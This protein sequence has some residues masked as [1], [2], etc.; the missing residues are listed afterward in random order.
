LLGFSSPKIAERL[1]LPGP[2]LSTA[3]GPNRPEHRVLDELPEAVRTWPAGQDRIRVDTG[4]WTKR[5]NTRRELVLQKPGLLDAENIVKLAVEGVRRRKLRY[6]VLGAVARNMP[7]DPL[8]CEDQP[9]RMLTYPNKFDQILNR[10]GSVRNG[11]A[12]VGGN[13]LLRLGAIGR[14]SR[15][16]AFRAH[17]SRHATVLWCYLRNDAFKKDRTI[18]SRRI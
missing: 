18:T 12:A 15:C 10:E 3:F 9:Q 11:A 16:R 13:D 5:S 8:H 4:L 14:S 1:H 2:T 17:Q 7:Q 6:G